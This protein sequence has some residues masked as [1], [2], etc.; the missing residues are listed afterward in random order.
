MRRCFLLVTNDGIFSTFH[1]GYH[2]KDASNEPKPLKAE[3]PEPGLQTR[4]VRTEMAGHVKV[5]RLATSRSGACEVAQAW[6]WNRA[7]EDAEILELWVQTKDRYD[8]A[9]IPRSVERMA[10]AS[11]TTVASPS[12]VENVDPSVPLRCP[13]RWTTH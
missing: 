3:E 10:R 12:K 1:I 13:G 11:S 5:R 7:L 4:Y 2:S 6:V 9:A 8:V